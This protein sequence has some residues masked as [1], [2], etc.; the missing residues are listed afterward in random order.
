MIVQLRIDERLIHGQ[1]AAAWANALDYTHI[2]CVSD[3][4]IKDPL[5]SKVLLMAAPHGKKT[6]IKSVDESIRLLSDERANKLKVFMIT[7]NPKNAATLVD[8]LGISEVNVANYHKHGVPDNEKIY[9]TGNCMTDREGMKDFE[10]LCASAKN[11]Y[12]QMLPTVE[13][14]DFRKLFEKINLSL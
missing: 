13:S 14:Q 6:F 3:I 2:L 11:V 5:R 8:A 4:A 1:I 7:D 9:I 10:K 12:S